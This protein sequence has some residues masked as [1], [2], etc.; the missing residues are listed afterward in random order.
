MVFRAGLLVVLFTAYYRCYTLLCANPRRF[1]S[2][3][4]KMTILTRSP[5]LSCSQVHTNQQKCVALVPQTYTHV[6]PLSSRTQAPTNARPCPP[7]HPTMPRRALLSGVLTLT[8]ALLLSQTAPPAAADTILQDTTRKF[9]RPEVQPPDAVRK[10]LYA[11]AVLIE[12]KVCCG[13]A[14][15]CVIYLQFIHACFKC[16][17]L[18]SIVCRLQSLSSITQPSLLTLHHPNASLHSP[19]QPTHIHTQQLAA[20]PADSEERVAA[21]SRLPTFA[22][23]LRE[24][25][26]ATPVVAGLVTGDSEG[27]LTEAYGGTGKIGQSI[28][29][30]IYEAVGRVCLCWGGGDVGGVDMWD[31]QVVWIAV[32]GCAV[33][34]TYV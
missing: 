16:V 33:T 25:G 17:L 30:P 18:L 21:R 23:Y 8:P 10:L 34:W 13:W 27:T 3:L 32:Y 4:Y 5:V 20:T 1:C 9:L 2:Q 11:K 24:V 15:V 26:P 29:V 7:S 14:E 12:M 31:G 19:P 6:V 22:K 28:S